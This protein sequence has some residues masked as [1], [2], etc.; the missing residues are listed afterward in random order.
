VQPIPRLWIREAL[1]SRLG[2]AIKPSLPSPASP[3]LPVSGIDS[4]G[5]VVSPL[6]ARLD[7]MGLGWLVISARSF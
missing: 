1:Q 4:I 6:E 7:V 3:A 5:W 2:L